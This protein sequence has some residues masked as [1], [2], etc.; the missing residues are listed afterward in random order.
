MRSLHQLRNTAWTFEGGLMTI[1]MR[2]LVF[3]A[4]QATFAALTARPA[5]A[6]A[7]PDR[8]EALIRAQAV[9]IE[10]LTREMNELR[11]RQSERSPQAETAAHR[12]EK[13]SRPAESAAEAVAP[14]PVKTP[15]AVGSPQNPVYVLAGD[16][17]L[18]WKLPGSDVSLRIGG[19]AKLDAIGITG[20]NRSVGSSDLFNPVAI[21]TRGNPTGTA[22]GDP[23]TRIHGRQSRIFLEASK[24]DTPFGPA[25]AYIEADF[26]G[27]IDLGTETVSNSNTFRL[28]HAYGEVGP[29]LGGQTWSTFSDP[30]S[31]PEILDFQGPGAQS[32]IRQGQVRYT[33]NFGGGLTGSVAVE[34]PES[35]I[36]I[37]TGP[38]TGTGTPGLA[39]G[40]QS[41][42][43]GPFARDSTPDF[44]ARIR[45]ESPQVN[46]QLSGVAT[47]STAPLPIGSAP[48][49]GGSGN[50]GFGTLAAG[51]IAIPFFNKKD[52]FRF[53]AGYLDGASR[54]IQDVA[55]SAPS[56][57]YNATLT[58]FD[59]IVAYGG[60]GAFQHWWTDALRTNLTYSIVR[61]NNPVFSGVAVVRE[62][63]YAT[64]NLLY[65]PWPD[66]DLGSEFQYGQREDADRRKGNQTRVQSSLIYRF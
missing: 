7:Q 24:T 52:N 14:R 12:A 3:I 10:K 38:V 19:Y 42:G 62:T 33:G 21:Q 29:L 64:I 41:L 50:F 5:N 40:L 9:Q 15:G 20:G 53:Q 57:A 49:V 46:F 61:I 65:S 63:Q 28:R 36:R 26:F 1:N 8:L 54:Y 44:V 43:V 23:S 60:F 32:F 55:G 37:G 45:Y 47:R 34:N 18:S 39:S 27:P 35:R 59:S 56:F 11:A 66:V 22:P 58:Q 25:R 4:L 51:Q 6:Q 48:V 17:K 13:A 31:Y 2:N 16:K 30:T